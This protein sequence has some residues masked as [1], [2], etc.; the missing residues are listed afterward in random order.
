MK[1]IIS[2]EEKKDIEVAR[3][4]K[5]RLLTVKLAALRLFDEDYSPAEVRHIL[6]DFEG[7]YSIEPSAIL[8]A[9]TALSGRRR[10]LQRPQENIG[11]RPWFCISPGI[12]QDQ[13]P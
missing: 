2:R 1:S 3:K 13:L 7:P 4:Y 11:R 9:D 5:L 10:S 6:H 8:Y 12:M